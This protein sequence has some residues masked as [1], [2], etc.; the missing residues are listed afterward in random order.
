MR[1]SHEDLGLF[2]ERLRPSIDE[3]IRKLAKAKFREDPIGGRKFSRATSIMSSA[4]KR[5]G[6]ILGHA[7]IERLR[8]CS[9]F[10]VW[11]EDAFKLSPTSLDHAQ[12]HPFWGKCASLNLPYGEGPK[13][14]PIDVIVFDKERRTLRSY[15]VKRGNGAYDAGKKD[16]IQS[17][18]LRVQMLLRGYGAVSGFDADIAEARIVFYYGLRSIEAPVSLISDELDDHFEFPVKSAIEAVNEYFRSR[19]YRLIDNE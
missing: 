14:I 18:L 13:A 7:L 17:E 3:T 4:Y 12:L 5:H 1:P 10:Q 15:N 19:L 6:Q 11:R 16:A 8:D 9:R 2:V